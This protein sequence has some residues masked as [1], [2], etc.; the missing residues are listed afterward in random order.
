MSLA[1][2]RG[3]FLRVVAG[4][5]PPAPGV[6]TVLATDD[7]AAQPAPGLCIARDR[8]VPPAYATVTGLTPRMLPGTQVLIDGSGW[9]RA[10]QPGGWDAQTL[11]AAVRELAAQ[12]IAAV[13]GDAH[14]GM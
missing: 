13:T 5:A 1:D 9:L 2:L 7:L 3:G 12:P 10:V 14:A 8:D 11:A 6:T 4:V